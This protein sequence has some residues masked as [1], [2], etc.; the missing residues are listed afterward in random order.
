MLPKAALG[1]CLVWSVCSMMLPLVLQAQQTEKV[2][3][4]GIICGVRCEGSGYELRRLGW[5]DGR[6]VR[7]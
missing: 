5:I 4:L 6:N 1:L 3:R 2:V 7:R